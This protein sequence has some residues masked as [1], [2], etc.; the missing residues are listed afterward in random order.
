MSKNQQQKDWY[1]KT[2]EKID[3]IMSSDKDIADKYLEIYKY[4]RTALDGEPTTADEYNDEED[5][6]LGASIVK[7]NDEVSGVFMSDGKIEQIDYEYNDVISQYEDHEIQSEIKD[8]IQ[9]RDTGDE[10][11]FGETRNAQNFSA[12]K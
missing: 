1:K 4:T 7:S 2:L 6:Q 11:D 3:N 9:H 5:V 10:N 12:S 8:F